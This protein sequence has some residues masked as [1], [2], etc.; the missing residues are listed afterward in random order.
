MVNTNV[1]YNGL[2]LWFWQ[3]CLRITQLTSFHF[4]FFTF[5]PFYFFTFLLT[6]FL[7]PLKPRLL[8]HKRWSFYPLNDGC[9]LCK[10]PA[11]TVLGII[12][13]TLG[14]HS[15]RLHSRCVLNTMQSYYILKGPW[16]D[17]TRFA[18]TEIKFFYGLADSAENADLFSKSRRNKRNVFKGHTDLT[19][20]T[21][22]HR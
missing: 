16:Q 1:N 7:F 10:V 15:F 20:L 14:R 4:D 21:D 17:L 11:F 2:G 13:L 6:S 22:L 18:H 9:L 12:P 19:D 8:P 5:L 3:S